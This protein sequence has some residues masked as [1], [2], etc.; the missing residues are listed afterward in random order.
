MFRDHVL[1]AILWIAYCLLHS[2]L[3]DLSIKKKISLAARGLFRYYRLFYTVFA[4]A[5]LAGIL[6]FLYFLESPL[7][8]LLDLPILILGIFISFSGVVLMIIC[9]S[10]YF[11][12]LSGLKSLFQETPSGT[13]MISGIHRHVRHP[14]YLGT[15]MFI[16]GL[17]LL[18]PYVSVLITNI[19]ITIYTLIGIRLEEQK[20]VQEF[21]ESY[22]RYRQQ[23]PGLL[24][25]PWRKGISR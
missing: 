9:I 19:I 6:Y 11:F 17:F 1:L 22:V 8:F 15:F 3:A 20:L 5:G 10:K 12:T 25:K 14:L 13:L 16:W 24:P 23:V 7:L 21:G 18:L 2:I 4:F